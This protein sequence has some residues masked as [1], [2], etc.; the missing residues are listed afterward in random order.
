MSSCRSSSRGA[1]RLATITLRGP[2]S[3]A[4]GV[5]RRHGDARRG[6]LAAASSRA[7]STTPSSTSAPTNSIPR[8]LV[9]KS[10]GDPAQ[11]LALRRVSRRQ[12]G[13]LAGARDQGI[14]E[15]HAQA[16][17]SHLAF[18]GRA[19]SSPAPCFAGTLAELV[20]A[21]DRSYML[22]GQLAG[23]NKPPATLSL[24]S[25]N[26]GAYPMSNGLSR[27][28]E[29]FPRRSG[30]RRSRARPKSASRSTPT[31]PSSSAS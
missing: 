14:V 15:A 1:Q 5:G 23:D 26:F 8:A 27:L 6:F 2:E 24:A 13:S 29:P 7:N 10:S 25:V 20:F 9:F 11:V 30:R 19:R 17:R 4:A 31:P 28:A 16:R 18:A 12:Q 3:A 22:I 21:T